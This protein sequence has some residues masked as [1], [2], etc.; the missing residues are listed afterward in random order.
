MPGNGSNPWP[1]SDRPDLENSFRNLESRPYFAISIDSD[2]R[3][4]I[5]PTYFESD[6]H[7]KG[8]ET[9]LENATDAPTGHDAGGIEVGSTPKSE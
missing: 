8:G 9:F 3:A 4:V 1:T 6:N 5:T 7:R 2:G